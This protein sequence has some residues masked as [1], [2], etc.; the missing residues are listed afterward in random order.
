MRSILTALCSTLGTLGNLYAVPADFPIVAEDLAVSLFARD[1]IVRNPCA[2]T[3]DSQGRP[4][5]GMG[6]Q[7]RSP[8]PDTEPDSVW[9]LKDQDKDETQTFQFSLGTPF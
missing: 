5:V 4:C 9:I 2:L 3:F 1:P 8:D 6:P 7:Y